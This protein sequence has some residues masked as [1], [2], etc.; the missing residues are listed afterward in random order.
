MPH[1]ED[2]IV[3]S[4]TEEMNTLSSQ[5]G[6]MGGHA[7]TILTDS[8]H[9]LLR[10]DSDLAMRAIEA[11]RRVDGLD[12]EIEA[13]V[14]R[15]LAL[16]QPVANDLRAVISALRIAQSIE[17]IADHAK[18]AG[19][20]TLT[21]NQ[22]RPLEQTRSIVR[23]YEVAREMLRGVLDAYSDSDEKKAV[24]VRDRD[25]DLD[26]LYD[27]YF[28]ECLTYM[29]EDSRMITATTHLLF[30]AKN[31]ERIGDQCTNIAENVYF[32]KTGERLGPARPRGDESLGDGLTA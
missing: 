23:L 9:A 22:T 11:D 30:I 17:R 29:M 3:T 2:H 4:F 16:R 25:Q 10:R 13:E 28:R 24:E 7:E 1:S 14:V 21:I 12:A 26:L 20:R 6:R 31:L 15:L 18:N 19:K 5:V 8:I 27:G 32:I